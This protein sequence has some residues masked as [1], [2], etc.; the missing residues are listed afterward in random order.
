MACPSSLGVLVPSSSV[1]GGASASSDIGYCDHQWTNNSQLDMALLGGVCYYGVPCGAFACHLYTTVAYSYWVVG[2]SPH[3]NAYIA[4]MAFSDLGILPQ[5]SSGSSSSTHFCDGVISAVDGTLKMA[6][7]GGSCY[8]GVPCGAFAC[9]L[10]NLV[11]SSDW[12]VGASPQT[13]HA[14]WLIKNNRKAIAFLL[15]L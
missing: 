9:D 13:K 4:V 2:A 6:L 1:S 3:T 14:H 11:A 15:T 12:A 8:D 10:Y 5:S 7:L